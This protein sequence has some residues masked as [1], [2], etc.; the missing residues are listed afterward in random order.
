L[1]QREHKELKVVSVCRALKGLKVLLDLR[2]KE[3]V[4]KELRVLQDRLVL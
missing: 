3:R 2:P 4:L 1:D